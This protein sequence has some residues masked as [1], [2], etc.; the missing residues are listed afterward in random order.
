MRALAARPPRGDD[1]RAAAAGLAAGTA[2]VG[3]GALAAVLTGPTGDPLVAVGGAFVDATP[4]WLKDWA[5]ATFGTADK[6]VLGIGEVVVLAVLAA[7]AGVLARRRWASGAVLVV[8]LG[9]LAALAATTRPDA[10][11]LAP[12]PALLG[13]GGG[14][15]ALR[16]LLARLPAPARR[17]PAG[18]P[19][20]S[21]PDRSDTAGGRVVPDRRTFLRATALVTAAGVVA[22]VV[23]RAV[24]SGAR[25]AAAARAS[26]RLP[27]PARPAPP[28]P[29]GVDV[30]VAGVEPWAT[31]V[32]DFYR[33]DTALVVPQVD[34]ATWRLRVHGLVEREVEI[35]W[36]EL[37]A[38]DLV[39]AWVT[40]ACVS[41]PVGGDLV[42]NQRWLG[43]PVREVL[44]RAM[45]TTEADMVLSR[46]VDGFTA[47]TPLEALTDG[48]DALLAVAMDGA[49]L[50]PEH[51]FPVR[52]VVPGLYGYVSATKWVTELEVTRFDR[53]DAYWTVRG[54]SPRGPV[55]TQSRIEVPRPGADVRAGDV[56]VAGTAWAQH[57]GVTQVQVR[58]DDGPWQDADLAADGGVDTWRQWR[59]RW[60]DAPA[61]R[62][63]LSVR[64]WDPDGPQTAVPAGAVPDGASGYDT[65]VVEV[66]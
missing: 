40:L 35:G 6:L 15:L 31:P 34:P 57:R 64:A 27:P 37:L 39:E 47:S 51:G 20:A 2:T 19:E 17:A 61:G 9:G 28:P 46:S 10:G 8:A 45:P 56:V 52:L 5:V 66:A 53:A 62:H 30:G 11:V 24:A 58:V 16:T 4:P 14:L 54:W 1:A 44:A 32:A 55:K 26:L 29:S 13:A 25:G 7:A 12:A 42:G 59:W 38:A 3:V 33:I 43:L 36:D 18:G 50:P 22:T 41:N 49:P 63:V 48:R 65:L 21:G 60:P 23:G